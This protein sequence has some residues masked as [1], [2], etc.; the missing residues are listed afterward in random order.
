VFRSVA[1]GLSLLALMTLP[2]VSHLQ[3]SEKLKILV[4]CTGNSARSQMTAGFLKSWDTRLDIYSAGTAPAPQ[5]NPYAVRAM[6]EVGIDIS[7][8]TPK[9]VRQFLGESFD[10]VITV[11]DEA[12]RDC[13]NFTGKVGKRVHIPFP[14]PARATGTDDQIMSVFRQVRNDIQAKFT[15]YYQHELKKRL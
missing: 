2:S 11:C 10:Y 5:I 12:D 3:A 15:D 9:N 8:G 4:I 6:K 14:D 1:K 13:P 7:S